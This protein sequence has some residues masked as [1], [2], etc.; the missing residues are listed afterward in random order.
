[1][2]LLLFFFYGIF[3]LFDFFRPNTHLGT[4]DRVEATWPWPGSIS[5][6]VAP[7]LVTWWSPISQYTQLTRSEIKLPTFPL[8]IMSMTDQ[9]WNETGIRSFMK[10]TTGQDIWYWNITKSISFRQKCHIVSLLRHVPSEKNTGRS[11]HAPFLE[12]RKITY[13]CYLISSQA[14]SPNWSGRFWGVLKRKSR[15]LIKSLSYIRWWPV[16]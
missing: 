1:M 14:P 3:G 5:G 16:H 7:N 12:N 2:Q 11:G 6:Q 9:V 4:C 8:R 15:I 13:A 10:I